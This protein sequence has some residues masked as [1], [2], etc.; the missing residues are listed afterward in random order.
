MSDL[1]NGKGGTSLDE[2]AFLLG[3]CGVGS[4]EFDSMKRF[5]LESRE[6]GWLQIFDSVLPAHVRTLVQ[7][8][9]IAKEIV[10]W[11]SLYIPGLLQTELYARAV[12]EDSPFIEPEEVPEWVAA[13]MERRGIVAG[14]KKFVFYLYEPVLRS[15]VGG[16]DVLAEQLHELVR[17]SVRP[18]IGMR[19]LPAG[20][21]LTGDFSLLKFEKFEP[22]VYRANLNSALFLEDKVSIGIYQEALKMMDRIALSREESRE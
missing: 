7:H 18:Y 10:H 21:A 13:R 8:E 19:I 6:K 16:A 22:L 11:S 3:M 12:A 2:F 4:D 15:P 1:V 5:F 14:H 17:M 20:R 9:R